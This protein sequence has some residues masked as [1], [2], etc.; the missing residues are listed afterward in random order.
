MFL[1]DPQ[2][3]GNVR[4]WTPN[5]STIAAHWSCRSASGSTEVRHAA[6]MSP[7]CEAEA[8]DFADRPAVERV[9]GCVDITGGFV[10]DDASP[11]EVARQAALYGPLTDAVRDLADATIRTTGRR[12]RDPRR[13]QPRSRR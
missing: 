13:A 10:R 9:L 2:L 8:I 11:E 7:H 1:V 3:P 5:S 6:S 4:C 12:R